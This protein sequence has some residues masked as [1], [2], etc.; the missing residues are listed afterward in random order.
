VD[1]AC[2]LWKWAVITEAKEMPLKER[3]SLS[4]PPHL[5]GGVIQCSSVFCLP[6]PESQVLRYFV[7]L[8]GYQA[9]VLLCEVTPF[10]DYGV[11]E[12]HIRSKK[13]IPLPTNILEDS[14]WVKQITVRQQPSSPQNVSL[15]VLSGCSV[16]EISHLDRILSPE[17][18]TKSPL[19]KQVMSLGRMSYLAIKSLEL[20]PGEGSTSFILECISSDDEKG[21]RRVGCGKQGFNELPEEESLLDNLRR[22]V[23]QNSLSQIV[24]HANCFVADQIRVNMA[25][26]LAGDLLMIGNSLNVQ[27]FAQ[28]F[29]PS[30]K[31]RIYPL[32]E[33]NMGQFNSFVV[34]S[35]NG[36]G[37]LQFVAIPLDNSG[38][39]ALPLGLYHLTATTT[40][41]TGFIALNQPQ[42]LYCIA[43]DTIG[44]VHFLICDQS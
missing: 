44:N 38:D 37:I 12:I 21:I 17:P 20:M 8:A 5:E 35:D 43:G 41:A 24:A 9:F 6:D 15:L 39:K 22:Y 2:H 27:L 16:F 3:F 1:G 4:S 14:L 31:S 33:M 18:A 36:D 10:F 25:V 29:I 42:R 40:C 13:W 34:A 30:N 7:A 28:T 32:C 23:K 26:T 11:E 19:V